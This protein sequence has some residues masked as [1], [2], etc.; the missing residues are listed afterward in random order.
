MRRK[1]Y[2]LFIALLV[3]LCLL[4]FAAIGCRPPTPEPTPT[5]TQSVVLSD[6]A[7]W[8]LGLPYVAGVGV[9]HYVPVGSS[10]FWGYETT[11]AVHW[12]ELETAPGVYDW[13][14]LDAYVNA[15]IAQGTSLWL[16][17]QTV[18]ANLANETKAPDWLMGLGAVWHACSLSDNNGL[19]APWDSVYLARL[20]SFLS[21]VNAHIA[22]QGAAYQDAI[23][24]IVMMSGGMYGE[25]QLWSCGM[26]DDLMAYYGL[27]TWELNAQY[28]VGIK[29]VIDVY[30]SSFPTLPMM[31]QVGYSVDGGQ[32]AVEEAAA[33]YAI[34]TLGGRALLKWNGWDPEAAGNAHY[35]ALFSNYAA[36]GTQ[37]GYEPGH[38]ALYKVGNI[39]DAS[40]F[41]MA[42]DVAVASGASFVC[43]QNSSDTEDANGVSMLDAFW[44]M[45]GA[46][47]FNDTLRSNVA[48]PPLT[49]TPYVAPTATITPTATP[50]P[51]STPTPT[52]TPTCLADWYE[53][54][55]SDPPDLWDDE[56]TSSTGVVN[57]SGVYSCGG[58]YSYWHWHD[59]P[60]PTP[61]AAYMSHDLGAN[62][63]GDFETCVR[64]TG[65]YTT[66]VT[67]MR[68]VAVDGTAP[69]TDVITDVWHINYSD[70][71]TDATFHCDVCDPELEWPLGALS[72]DNWYT[73]RVTWDLPVDPGTGSIAVTKN[74][75]SVVNSSGI[76]MKDVAGGWYAAEAAQ[77]GII[78]WDS[79][80]S[81]PS[82]LYSDE[83]Y[84][85][86]STV[87]CTP[88]PTGTATPTHTPTITPTGTITPTVWSTPSVTPTPGGPTPTLTRTPT[89]AGTRVILD[90]GN[91]SFL[92]ECDCEG[93]VP[94]T[95]AT[96]TPA[97]TATPVGDWFEC[98][99]TSNEEWN[100]S[101]DNWGDW[102]GY[103]SND[104][105]GLSVALS[106]AQAFDG[107]YSYSHYGAGGESLWGA[108]FIDCSGIKST[109]WFTGHVYFDT[110]PDYAATENAFWA[111]EYQPDT[112]GASNKRGLYLYVDMWTAP[113]SVVL[114]CN[115]WT[116][117]CAGNE[118]WTAYSGITTG[119]WYTYTVYWD[120]P[121]AVT[122]GLVQV[123]W[124]GVQT[125]ND[126]T[127]VTLGYGIPR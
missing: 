60:A 61:G 59:E 9:C 102:D 53:P 105:R 18:G 88:A 1:L 90:N 107:D 71:T 76:A 123:W 24:G 103:W 74:G 6:P 14:L 85:R 96:V 66:P 56:C 69:C 104:Y 44:Q 75:G 81:G 65:T 31:L 87:A 58:T 117:Y 100:P 86:V 121:I 120:L 89:P 106:S 28:L 122:D 49:P 47:A 109:G 36:G 72:T 43:Y 110:M 16:A 19:L 50:T 33:D 10:D 70:P 79:N 11:T 84:D 73:L 114:K 92:C 55:E 93:A 94:T 62:D 91:D 34:A 80:A 54:D 7:G 27:T 118:V 40:K 108:P 82:S 25:M 51:T 78:D 77:A 5:P 67:I 30:D 8:A 99:S 23:G 3:T 41:D 12:R 17:I 26:R 124:N 38:P 13:T 4:G 115:A 101:L 63:N 20:S 112:Y 116:A 64:T 97:A 119:Q 15:R 113:D 39:Y 52:V 98:F 126:N 2:L 29:D 37:V 46:D 68:A 125:V 22:A 45:P 95:T 57:L 35:T 111:A 127:V 21:A 48:E 32:A 42:W 83:A